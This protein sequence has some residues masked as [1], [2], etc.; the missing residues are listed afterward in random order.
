[1]LL[2]GR[3]QGRFRVEF[4][5]YVISHASLEVLLAVSLARPYPVSKPAYYLRVY[6]FL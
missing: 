5:G 2:K 6:E 1:M 3:S 4:S